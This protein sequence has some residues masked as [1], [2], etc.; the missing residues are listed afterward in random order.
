LFG[1]VPSVVLTSATLTTGPKDHFAYIRERLNIADARTCALGSPYDYAR[2]VKVY[3]ET[4]L[5]EP[6][7]FEAFVPR[8]SE[9]I[10]AYVRLT[11]GRAFVLFTSYAMM[12]RCADI[13]AP[14]FADTGIELMVQGQNLPR[15]Q[16]IERFRADVRSV[17]FGT[18][19]FWGGVD[20]PGE[21]LSNVIIVKLPFAVPDHPSIEARI[22]QI[23]RRG[24]NPFAE[25]QLPEAI[26]KFKQGF[27]RLIRSREDRGIVAILDPRV[28]TKRYGKAFLDALPECEIV[29]RGQDDAPS[30]NCK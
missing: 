24:G 10:E 11:D 28:H 8:A 2:Q 15:S 6:N 18:S 9:A 12:N 20:V 25:F 4:A 17:I 30:T 19:S 13:L 16:M 7:N 14:F 23:R 1:V 22:E 29:L 26:L 21:A 27:G 3:V 5:P